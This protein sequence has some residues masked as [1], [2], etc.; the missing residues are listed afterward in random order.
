MNEP[1]KLRKPSW[2]M[3]LLVGWLAGLATAAL[4]A[5][6]LSPASGN[7]AAAPAAPSPG[8]ASGAAAPPAPASSSGAIP[9]HA[10]GGPR[11]AEAQA[12]IAP[13]E[14]RLAAAPDDLLTR[15]ELALMLLRY[16]QLMPAFEQASAVRKSLPEDPDGLYV[17]GVVR[18]RMGQS[19]KAI[20]L[21]ERLLSR[22]PEHVLALTALGKAQ[23][24]IGDEAGALD[25]WNK[26]LA[27]AGGRHGEVERLLAGATGPFSGS[28][29]ARVPPSSGMLSGAEAAE[30]VLEMIATHQTLGSQS[31][32]PQSQP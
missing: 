27:A 9:Q 1:S 16:D 4:V 23:R 19:L 30:A 2:Q 21:L 14:A 5:L 17:H 26:A 11:S 22:Y 15:K 12:L 18:L 28:T 8:A 10:S 24:K 31:S 25:S 7:D 20:Q 32:T 3:P 29:A 6:V 13:L